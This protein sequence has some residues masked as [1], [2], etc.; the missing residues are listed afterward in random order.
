MGSV[1]RSLLE[2]GAMSLLMVGSR[3]AA[4][5]IVVVYDGSPSSD[6]ALALAVALAENH[7]ASFTVILAGESRE[8][9]AQAAARLEQTGIRAVFETFTAP[10]EL[11]E[12]LCRP[13]TGTMVVPATVFADTLQRSSLVESLS[14]SVFVVR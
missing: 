11:I 9:G 14:C 3:G 1:T 12:S 8:L 5:P 2:Q 10:L 7:A 4:G 6:R 13:G